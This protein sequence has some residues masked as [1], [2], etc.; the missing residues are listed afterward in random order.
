MF[1]EAQG[2]NKTIRIDRAESEGCFLSEG[3]EDAMIIK[4]DKFEFYGGIIYAT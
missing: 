1:L 3:Q 4:I 2:K